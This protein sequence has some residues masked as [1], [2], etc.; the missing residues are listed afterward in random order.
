MD[1]LQQQQDPPF[2]RG[3]HIH[4]IR[5]HFSKYRFGTK[6]FEELMFIVISR[7]ARLDAFYSDRHFA[8][9]SRVRLPGYFMFSENV[10]NKYPG[11]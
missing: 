1:E 3:L 9:F 5:N 11:F 4:E 7:M 10:Q 2:K 6:L 8:S